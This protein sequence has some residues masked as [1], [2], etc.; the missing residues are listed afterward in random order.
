ML[1]KKGDKNG[2]VTLF[3]IIS[4]LIVSSV[5][6][7]FMFKD[8]FFDKNID[9]EFK[10]LYNSYIDCIKG[11]TK[12][13]IYLMGQQGGYI[14]LPNFEQGSRFMPFSS[15]LDF[16]GQK[17]PYWFY[18]SGNN[19]IRKQIPSKEDMEIQLETFISDRLD[20]CDLSVYESQGF[21]Y[22]LNDSGDVDVKINDLSVEVYINNNLNFY[23]ND[24]SALV[25]THEFSIPSKLGKFYSS[26][27]EIYD[28]EMQT[29]FL[30]KYA[31]DVLMNYVPVVGF[32]LQC[33]PLIFN[34][35]EIKQ[36][37]TN[38]LV[39]NINSIKMKGNYYQLNDIKEE[40]FVVDLSKDSFD[41]LVNVFYN[42]NWPLKLE[43][44]G[45]LINEPVGL[46]EGL[47]ML[48]FCY[49]PYKLNYDLVFPVLIQFIED[50]FIFQYPINVIIENTQVR[51]SINQSF[52]ESESNY[53][54]VCNYKK[55][56]L[57]VNS[58]DY[59]LNPLESSLTF[60]CLDSNCYLG[61]SKLEGS[62]ATFN[63]KVPQ[64]VNGLLL[65]NSE[66]Y[67]ETQ[68][69]ISTNE[70]LILDIWL[71]KKYNFNLEMT[72]LD[73]EKA[74]ISFEGEDYSTSI[75]Y[76]EIKS[77]E[78]VEDNYN[79][80]IFVYSDSS[81]VLPE[82]N[83]ELCVN[84]PVGG[85]G[86]VFGYEEEKCENINIPSMNIDSA[87]VGGGSLVNYYITE[88]ILMNSK[89]L[90]IVPT[91]FD[92][93]KNLNELQENYIKVEDSTVYLNFN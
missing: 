5:I 51:E 40:Y 81:L 24:K 15:Q 50:D 86:S 72:N 28:Y 31:Y 37:I 56:N 3:I 74:L 25:S 83:E 75:V 61:E 36:N 30:E 29:A 45:D 48:G 7:F 41:E 20:F 43:I 58:Y 85:M 77:L 88:D 39:A 35:E 49:V 19:L 53:Y 11:T 23:F 80:S 18:V 10:P 12:E 65:V 4:I 59:N 8:N 27:I 62:F 57:I 87:I 42:P 93:P 91:L 21:N 69:V 9:P 68:K 16:L 55:S 79:I 66:G 73:N 60:K 44:N 6:L 67:L 64:C 47:E 76:P 33:S 46:Q 54:D 38:G 14:E 1:L 32:E 34:E 84:V 70:D 2:Q 92:L 89:N 71:K 82:V 22:I 52:F 13:G 26:S 63:D 90:N 78:L 17:I